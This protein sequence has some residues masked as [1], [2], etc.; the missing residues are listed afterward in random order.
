MSTQCDQK[1]VAA[2]LPATLVRLDLSKC[3]KALGLAGLVRALRPLT[4]L[5]AL[6]LR[7]RQDI[8]HCRDDGS[9]FLALLAH[10]AEEA[11]SVLLPRLAHLAADLP[12]AAESLGGATSLEEAFPENPIAK[13]LVARGVTVQVNNF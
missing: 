1:Q 11:A 13:A 6:G 7:G 8:C 3:A 12:M 5:E 2:R 9:S 4:A 10:P